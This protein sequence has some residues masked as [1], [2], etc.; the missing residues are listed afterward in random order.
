MSMNDTIAELLVDAA[1][2][3]DRKLDASRIRRLRESY[4]VLSAAGLADEEVVQ[5]LAITHHEMKQL[6]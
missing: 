6:R 5:V 3:A 4:A 1:E 2:Q